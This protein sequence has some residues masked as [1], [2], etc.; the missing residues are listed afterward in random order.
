MFRKKIN[1]VSLLENVV[2]YHSITGTFP[3]VRK[4]KLIMLILLNFTI[5]TCT[6]IDHMHFLYWSSLSSIGLLLMNTAVLTLF[7]FNLLCLTEAWTHESSWM[8]FFSDIKTFDYELEGHNI[9]LEESICKYCLQFMLGSVCYLTLQSCLHF[10]WKND[11]NLIIAVLSLSN[12]YVVNIQILVTFLVLERI[13]YMV[14]KRYE[15]LRRKIGEVYSFKNRDHLLWNSLRL[16]NSHLLLTNIT[17]NVDKLFGKRI[18]LLLILVF[19][20]VLACFQYEILEDFQSRSTTFELLI[21][22]GIELSAF[23]VSIQN[24][25]SVIIMTKFSIAL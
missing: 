15:I 8:N 14:V 4:Y 19:L 9:I 12:M 10:S 6:I 1:D 7:L 24:Y 21:G 11:V 22:L 13:L 18:L 17:R 2:R 23:L 25:S 3:V 20:D 5:M 16:K